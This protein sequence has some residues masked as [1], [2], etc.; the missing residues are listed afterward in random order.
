MFSAIREGKP[1]VLSDAQNA[2]SEIINGIKQN[3]L[4]VWLDGVRRY[5]EGTF[6]HC[7]LVS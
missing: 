6:Q 5:H 3:G 4:G 1:L 7:L 2:T